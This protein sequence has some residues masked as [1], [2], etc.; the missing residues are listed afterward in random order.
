MSGGFTV[1]YDALEEMAGVL[2]DLADELEGLEDHM[3]GYSD[4]VADEDVASELDRV[5]SNWSDDRGE[6][7]EKMRDTSEYG[8]QAACAYRDSDTGLGSEFDNIGNG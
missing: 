8:T 5:A 6:I 3:D 2:S 1:D 7:V 4:A